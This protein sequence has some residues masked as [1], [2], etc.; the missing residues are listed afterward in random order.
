MFE[1]KRK[2]NVQL[3]II[4][5]LFFYSTLI[6]DVRLGKVESQHELFREV[7]SINAFF[8]AP[9]LHPLLTDKVLKVLNSGG[10]GEICY[11]K[12]LYSAREDILII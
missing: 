8:M 10:G 11:R 9:R 7:K 4:S 2:G 6:N 3:G 1:L 5:E 12:L